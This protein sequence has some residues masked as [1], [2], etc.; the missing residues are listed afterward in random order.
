[1]NT[2]FHSQVIVEEMQ[3]MFNLGHRKEGASLREEDHKLATGR[4]GMSRK[5]SAIEVS[6]W[7]KSM[8]DQRERTRRREVLVVWTSKIQIRTRWPSSRQSMSSINSWRWSRC[9]KRISRRRELVQQVNQDRGKTTSRWTWTRPE[10]K[11]TEV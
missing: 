4:K 11:E 8:K 9:I 6:K 5:D 2:N 7:T 10:W 3:P 1:M